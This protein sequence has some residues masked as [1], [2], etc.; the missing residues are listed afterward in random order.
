MKD[1]KKYFDFS[2]TISG[3]TFLLRNLIAG[4]VAFIGG[5]LI[6][7]GIVQSTGLIMLGLLVLAPACWLSIT[8]IYKRFNA[9]YPRSAN[10][11]TIGLIFLQVLSGFGKG[12]IWGDLISL[13]LIVI[14][15]V[16]IFRNS[17]IENHE[18]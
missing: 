2:G 12:E 18:G 11:Y 13:V 16:L 6:G 3:S 5:F 14:A 8:N 9:L 17:N 7:Y 4:V 1:L 10:E 15:C